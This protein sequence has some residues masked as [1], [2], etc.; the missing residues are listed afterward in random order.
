MAPP[1]T[2]S[3]IGST[4]A[5]T[6]AWLIVDDADGASEPRPAEVQVVE[7]K[8]CLREGAV[9]QPANVGA[10][11]AP[12]GDGLTS[13]RRAEVEATPNMPRFGAFG[14][15]DYDALTD[16]LSCYVCARWKRNLAQHARLAYRLSADAYRALA[17]LNRSTKLVTPT[18]RAPARS[19]RPR[20]RAVA[21]RG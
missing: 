10:S 18:M 17:G 8:C 1:A 20:D 14:R 21:R 15:L 2:D 3:R 12:R 13:H 19:G 11:R 7:Q 9:R 5:C 16:A 4:E 6:A